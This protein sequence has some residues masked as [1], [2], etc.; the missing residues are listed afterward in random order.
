MAEGRADRDNGD[1][2]GAMRAFA[3]ADGIMHV[4]TTG[5]EVAR[6]EAALGLLVEA[7][8]TALR[9][10]RMAE[11]LGEPAPFKVA[12][13]AAGAVKSELEARIPLLTVT[14]ENVPPGSTEAVTIDDVA[15]PPGNRAQP[16]ML[17]PG[18]HRVS[19]RA[20]GADRTQEI[21]LIERDRKELRLALPIETAV[22]GRASG[23]AT[24]TKT[25]PQAGRS[26]LRDWRISTA[27]TLAAFGLA[28]AGLVTGTIAG[29]VSLAKTHAIERSTRCAGSV[30]GPEEYGDIRA[31]RWMATVSTLSFAAAAGAVTVGLVA[32]LVGSSSP[33]PNVRPERAARSESAARVEPWLGIRSAGL[34]GT[35]P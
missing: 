13:D 18:R 19:A 20:A 10:S 21:D 4:P 26:G 22:L 24:A 27:W 6:T 8:D 12:R 31:A 30:C 7:W 23:V 14:V 9:V 1:L 3:G 35:F 11:T 29:V 2:Q 32:V 15:V 17:D 5:L 34:R 16:R 33:L 25:G 28:G